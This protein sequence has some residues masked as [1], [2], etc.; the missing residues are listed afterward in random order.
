MRMTNDP[1]NPLDGGVK[2]AALLTWYGQQVKD[3]GGI[4][5]LTLEPVGI[6]GGMPEAGIAAMVKQIR[7]I[8]DFGV[9]V[10]LRFGH[11]MNGD[12]TEYGYRP[13]Y[14]IDMFRRMA[15][16]IH[17]GTTQ[18]AMLWSPNVGVNYPFT[19]NV[20]TAQSPWQKAGQV[21]FDLMDSNGDGIIDAAD[22]PYGP[23]WPGAEYVDWVGLSLYYYQDKAI[24]AVPPP[25]YF[26]DYM[27]GTN[28]VAEGADPDVNEAYR[29]FYHRFA[30]GMG[31]PM[32]L[33]ESG[34]G[35]RVGAPGAS[36]L[37]LKQGWWQQTLNLTNLQAHPL[38]KLITNFEEKKLE[39]GSMKDWSYT[40]TPAILA[41]YLA[42]VE[43][44][45]NQ[46]VWG[47]QIA[48]TCSNAIEIPQVV[49]GPAPLAAVP[50]GPAVN[51][52]VINPNVPAPA[53]GTAPPP[54][55]VSGVAV[56]ATTAP[57]AAATTAPV[58]PV[59][60]VAATATDTTDVLPTVVVPG[61]PVVPVAA[62]T[63]DVGVPMRV[64]RTRA[65]PAATP[66]LAAP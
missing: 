13:T 4:L 21:D 65:P 8:N 11:E 38:L 25:G 47:D 53:E 31:K 52:P 20:A 51:P 10:I 41:P 7:A 19:T 26:N 9:P 32:A 6:L 54:V 29:D 60:P 55:H 59:V 18:T 50:A 49:N 33:S 42:Y 2:S 28:Q 62:S 12:W 36:E 58:A 57:S 17:S 22:D 61:P 14:F 34:P 37:A 56:P 27:L 44:L 48:L 43:S 23:Y 46:L 30:A 40:T 63:A 15:N 24:N 66:V 1:V 5:C 16:A 45:G 39:D 64:P 35:Y 3:A